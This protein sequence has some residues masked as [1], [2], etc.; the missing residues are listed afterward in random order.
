MCLS[1]VRAAPLPYACGADRFTFDVTAQK[2]QT[3]PAPP[4]PGKSQIVFIEV[5]DR[6][7]TCFHCDATIRFGIDGA[8]IGANQANSYFAI[9]VVPGQ[10]RLCVASQSTSSRP[11]PMI[12]SASFKAEAGIT[13]Y[14]EAKVTFQAHQPGTGADPRHEVDGNLDLVQVGDD[15]GRRLVKDLAFS[16]F[17]PHL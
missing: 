1:R 12:G 9:D 5:V 6:N 7:S 17:S 8:W 2:I 13:Y 15:E 3:A 14:F 4:D 16:T 11:K 10:H